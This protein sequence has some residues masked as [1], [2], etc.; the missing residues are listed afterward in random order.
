[1]KG[2]RDLAS[3]KEKY[4]YEEYNPDYPDLFNIEKKRILSQLNEIDNKIHH[5]GSTA[6]QNIGGKGVIDIFIECN[7]SDIQKVSK[8]LINKLGYEYRKSGGNKNR[9][10]HQIEIKGRRYHV[11]LTDFN[12]EEIIQ[13]LTFRDFLCTHSKLAKEYSEIKKLA[14]A[15]A[16]K[17]N[18]K[19]DM[20]RV[21][22]DTKKPVV[23]KIIQA[24][25]NSFKITQ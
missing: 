20:K 15:R 4:K 24:S 22:T 17:E 11:H 10:F 25:K 14:S 21:Y 7:K 6:I 18:N 23:D 8:I 16:L 2:L 9:L 19:D 5:I 12:N 13:S 1:M 3:L